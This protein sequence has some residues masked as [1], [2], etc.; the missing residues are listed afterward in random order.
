MSDEA[1]PKKL[2][3]WARQV[4]LEAAGLRSVDPADDR[5]VGLE[6]RLKALEQRVRELELCERLGR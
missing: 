2:A 6:G 5:L 1:K 3:P 4:L